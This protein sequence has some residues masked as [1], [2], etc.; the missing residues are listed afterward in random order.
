MISSDPQTDWSDNS[1]YQQLPPWLRPSIPQAALSRSGSA[2]LQ[3]AFQPDRPADASSPMTRNGLSGEMF[4]PSVQSGGATGQGTT[5][6]PTTDP[7]TTGPT[8]AAADVIAGN[9]TRNPPPGTVAP[10][11]PSGPPPAPV[12]SAPP[13][14]APIAP[15]P[16]TPLDQ[17]IAAAEQRMQAAQDKLGQG[18]GQH[19]YQRLGMAL[20]SATKLAPYAQQIV[21]P[22]WSQQ[23]GQYESAEKDLTTLEQ[24]KEAEQRGSWYAAQAAGARQRP[25]LM[26]DGSLYDPR[27]GQTVM[28]A[29]TPQERKEQALAVGADDQTATAWALGMKPGEATNTTSVLHSGLPDQFKGLFT[30]DSTGHV[31]VPNTLLDKFQPTGEDAPL[32]AQ[33]VLQFNALLGQRYS[34]LHPNAP[35]PPAYQLP[36]NATVRDYQNVE[37]SLSGEESASQTQA[38]QAASRALREQTFELAKQARADQE[39]ARQDKATQAGKQNAEKIFSPVMDSAERF[40]V[41]S[42]NYEDAIKNHDQQAMLSLLYNHM[43]MT[44]GLQKGAR[45]TQALINEAVKSRPWLQGISTKFDNNG[46]LTGVTLSPQQMREMVNNAQGRFSEDMQKA[47]NVAQYMGIT[48]TGPNRV[49]NRA[50]IN[51]YTALAGGDPNRAKQLAANDGWTVQ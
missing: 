34:V 4:L 37:R 17:P 39:A 36:A 24:A 2:F 14:M 19:W 32:G 47:R 49:P 11:G 15:Q 22:L 21:H 50:T 30:P 13:G 26:K 5:M 29:P 20:L 31:R 23:V 7:T 38:S 3:D 16:T 44:M 12:K 10:A 27:T 46:Y 18:P 28:A 8:A 51:Y 1:V 35:L 41:M 42:Q 43:G 25:I 48:D 45:M 6:Q 9:K 40:N 33:R